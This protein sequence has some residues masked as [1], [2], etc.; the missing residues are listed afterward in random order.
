LSSNTFG[1]LTKWL[2]NDYLQSTDCCLVW[3]TTTWNKQFPLRVFTTLSWA[4]LH[5]YL[6]N[7]RRSLVRFA[8]SWYIIGGKDGGSL[9]ELEAYM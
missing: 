5:S 6:V 4:V 8:A 7:N 2:S 3:L 1:M 9:L